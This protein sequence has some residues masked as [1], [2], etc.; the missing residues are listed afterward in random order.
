MLDS[1]DPEAVRS[2]FAHAATSLFVL[3]S[4]S[5]STIEPNVMAAEARRRLEAAG[6]AHWGSRFIAITDEGTVLHKRAQAEQFREIFVNP[7]GHRWALLCAL[8]VRDGAC[9]VDGRRVTHILNCTPAR[10]SPRVR[11]DGNRKI[12]VSSWA[13]HGRG[14]RR[15]RDKLT[16]LLPEPLASFGL[17]VEQLVA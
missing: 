3:A 8:A 1:T 15:E 14:R 9:R 5:G 13:L 10:W 12:Q 4:K 11:G 7:S 17:W 2:A 6:I 16:V